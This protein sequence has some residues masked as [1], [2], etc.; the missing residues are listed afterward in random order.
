[1]EAMAMVDCGRARAADI[2]ISRV[3][4]SSKRPGPL[5][6]PYDR[7]IQAF[8]SPDLLARAANDFGAMRLKAAA[9]D[10]V[11][12]IYGEIGERWFD[13]APGTT[14]Q[15]VEEKLRALSGA[16]LEIRINSGGGD[17]FE[18]FAIYNVLRE[19]AGEITVKVIGVA[20]SAASIVAMAGDRIEIGAIAYFM[21][22][23]CWAGVLGNK[24]KLRAAADLFE[25]FDGSMAQVYAAR[26]GQDLSDIINWMIADTWFSG[27]RA[28]ELGF[29]DALLSVDQMERSEA[30]LASARKGAEVAAVE[31]ALMARGKS[32]AAA[33]AHIKSLRSMPDAAPETKPDAGS[34]A[35]WEAQVAALI[36]NLKG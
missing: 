21:I 4:A 27:A 30:A 5:A 17:M 24:E 20:G 11:L 1:M 18:G 16:P 15:I 8:T 2:G 32:R 26:S 12:E 33:R 14:V 28:I 34:Q 36:T 35:E 22:H 10:G 29:A 3:M 9:S 6:T 31:H 19:Y 23:N 25:E 7:N 13:E